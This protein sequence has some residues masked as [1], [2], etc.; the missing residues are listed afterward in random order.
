MKQ[1]INPI[2][3]LPFSEADLVQSAPQQATSGV[4]NPITGLPFSEADI[5]QPG[6]K[7]QM[8]P[9][10]PTPPQEEPGWFQPGSKSE[11][12][13]RG[14]SQTATLG[15]G[16]EIQAGIRSL[17]GSGKYSEL[18]DEQRAANRS[19]SEENPEAYMAGSAA[20]I[21]PTLVAG[22]PRVTAEAAKNASG[23]FVSTGVKGAA[24]QLARRTAG[25]AAAGGAYGGTAGLGY[26]EGEGQLG[27]AAEGAVTGAAFGGLLSFLGGAA[28]EAGRQF[29]L[30]KTKPEA[31]IAVKDV[32]KR[33]AK[34][35]AEEASKFKESAGIAAVVEPLTTA[36]VAATRAGQKMGQAVAGPVFRAYN[37]KGPLPQAARGMVERGAPFA[38]INSI[39]QEQDHGTATAEQVF[40]AYNAKGP[41]P[42]AARGMV[43]R[44][45]PFAAINSILQEQDPVYRQAI[46]DSEEK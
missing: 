17:L 30:G 13:V 1:V 11:A 22:A 35:L 36:T 24:R 29:K 7:A 40:S 10:E 15:F 39:L 26:A 8:A 46:I 44:G 16:D 23:Q 19:A 21:A 18:R 43:E 14:F 33:G 3:G 38:A 6:A 28:G 34:E 5:V 4:I 20:A 37:A 12:A 42:Q 2:T 45:A 31:E 32:V 27:Q 41:L 9:F 25:G